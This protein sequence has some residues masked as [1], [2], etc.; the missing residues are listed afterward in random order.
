[1]VNTVG[2]KLKQHKRELLLGMRRSGG[3]VVVG[4]PFQQNDC[5][6]HQESDL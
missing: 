1:M 5:T 4:Y 6:P 3:S 2:E